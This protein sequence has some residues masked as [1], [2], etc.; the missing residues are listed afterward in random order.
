MEGKKDNNFD[1]NRPNPT[2][3]HMNYIWVGLQQLH[4][5]LLF[6]PLVPFTT[7]NI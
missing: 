4:P 6:G 1:L 5:H 7:S 3:I 2:I